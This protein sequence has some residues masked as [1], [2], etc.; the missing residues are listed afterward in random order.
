M[1]ARELLEYMQNGAIVRIRWRYG[2]RI[3]SVC[4]PSGETLP[5]QM[6]NINALTKQHKIIGIEYSG[7]NY[8]Y[9]YSESQAA[10]S[11]NKKQAVE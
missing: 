11:E 9:F 10:L 3:N 8:D 4:L 5:T 2:K 7:N 1:N 6:S